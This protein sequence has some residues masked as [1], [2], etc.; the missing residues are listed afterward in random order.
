MDTWY[1]FALATHLFWPSVLAN[2]LTS[3]SLQ[4]FQMKSSVNTCESKWLSLWQ[5]TVEYFQ[6]YNLVCSPHVSI[7]P[8]IKQS[9][10]IEVEEKSYCSSDSMIWWHGYRDY[11]G[12]SKQWSWRY[13]PKKLFILK[14]WGTGIKTGVNRRLLINFFQ[15]AT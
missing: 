7:E 13:W 15:P 11:R 12:F 3:C 4:Q 10:I 8:T 1:L 2:F 5:A 14:N 9:L 6:K